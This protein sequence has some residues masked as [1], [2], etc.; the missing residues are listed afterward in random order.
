[1]LSDAAS[2]ADEPDGKRVDIADVKAAGISAEFWSQIVKDTAGVLPAMELEKVIAVIGIAFKLL[3][4]PADSA[5]TA[6]DV[7]RFTMCDNVF[8]F[9]TSIM[10]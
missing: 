3:Y 4:F 10:G 7:L 9:S 6:F 5:R 2:S 1:M 8:C